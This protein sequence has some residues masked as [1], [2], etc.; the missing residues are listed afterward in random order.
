VPSPR[1]TLVWLQ[2]DLTPRPHSFADATVHRGPD[3][4]DALVGVHQARVA[5]RRL[6]EVVPVAAV[7]LSGVRQR[8]LRRTLRDM[9]R[10]LGAVRECDVALGMIA[11][12]EQAAAPAL[13][14]PLRAWTRR[15]R[16]RRRDARPVLLS[17][18]SADRVARVGAWIDD[19]VAARLLSR[20]DGWRERL[21]AQLDTRAQRL[22]HAIDEAGVLFVPDA[23]HEVRI[24]AKKL[25]YAIELVGE[26]RLA[27]V[28]RQLS[29]LKRMQDVLGRLH[30]LDV[31][32]ADGPWTAAPA[33]GTSAAEATPALWADLVAGLDGE[34]RLLHAT[35]LRRRATLVRLADNVRDHLVARA[36]PST[37]V[38]VAASGTAHA[39]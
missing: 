36:R 9:T 30:D 28:T 10:A 3:V 32:L 31:L 12:L 29:T 21:S 37:S 4:V 23:L 15:V 26:C 13:L 2:D 20:D 18:C 8:R 35:Y 6:R 25:R 7:H 11:G 14:A 34:R 38:Q 19:L 16:E 5:T 39:V 22:R 17:V 27:S 24:A 33:T 1:A